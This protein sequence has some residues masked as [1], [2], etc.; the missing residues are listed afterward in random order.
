[1]RIDTHLHVYAD[2]EQGLREIAGFPIV[3]YGARD[4]VDFLRGVGG[5]VEQALDALAEGG[6][7][8]AAMLG[9]FELPDY[10]LPPGG[11]RHWPDPIAH[12]ELRDDLAAYNRWLCD[13]GAEHPA[14]LPFVTA[15]PAVMASDDA[16]EH[17]AEAFGDWGAR[18]MKLHPIAIHTFP[19]DP[20]LRGVY[21][22]AEEARAPIVFHSGPDR[23][24]FGWAEPERFAS[25]ARERP[26]LRIVLAHLGGGSFGRIATFAREFP[27][28][29]F[30]LSEI[31]NWAGG[32]L[33]PTAGEL[34]DIVRAVGVERVLLGSDF[35]WY[36]PA[37]VAELVE[38]LPRLGPAE[39]AAILGENAAR[40][41]GL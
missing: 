34:V 35:P 1:M 14:L 40:L 24:G 3:E 2:P 21:D 15:N 11:A 9:S 5:S 33:A 20:G 23:R 28:V 22:A 31:V 19:D 13:I 26:G 16:R 32:S 8:H 25:I 29:H 6:F 17:L 12:P 41:I 36:H 7:D 4:D 27:G 38:G 39:K 10:P 18:G 37:R 30:D